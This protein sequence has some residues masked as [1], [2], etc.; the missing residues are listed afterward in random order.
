MVIT[1]KTTLGEI[2]QE[3]P[4]TVPIV[5]QYGLHCVGCHVAGSESL[6]DGA[7]AHGLKEKDIKQLLKDIN[8]AI[9]KKKNAPPLTFTAIAAKK[10]KETL[11]KEKR[12]ALRVDAKPAEKGFSY[13][14]QLENA[15]QKGDMVLK[16]Q[17]VTVHIPKKALPKLRGSVIDF[18]EDAEGF[19]INNPNAHDN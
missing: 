15:K 10:L 2:L 7:R 18:L 14:M 13:D 11:K 12:K 4:E 9:A 5:M 8:A 17:G 19:R 6:G 3:H 1:E 16:V